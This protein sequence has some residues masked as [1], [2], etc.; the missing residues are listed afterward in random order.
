MP[1]AIMPKREIDDNYMSKVD[2]KY[3]FSNFNFFIE[4]MEDKKS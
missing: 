4:Y 3:F 1:G 2:R